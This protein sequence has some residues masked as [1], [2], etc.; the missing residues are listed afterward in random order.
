MPISN[1]DASI[2]PKGKQ[3]V[4]FTFVIDDKNNIESEKKK[5][6]ELIFKAVPGIEKDRNDTL[7]A[8]DP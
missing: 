3:L 7:P 1:Y 2:A 6:L 8:D 4:G 5:A